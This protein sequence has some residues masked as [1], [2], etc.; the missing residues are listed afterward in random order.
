M[1]KKLKIVLLF[2]FILFF[3]ACDEGNDNPAVDNPLDDGRSESGETN[4]TVTEVPGMGQ[5][6]GALLA[7]NDGTEVAA[8][9]ATIEVESHPEY[10]TTAD[11]EGKVSISNM[12]PGTYTIYAS[13]SLSSAVASTEIKSTATDDRKAQ[14]KDIVVTAAQ[15]TTLSTDIVLTKPGSISGTVELLN[16]PNNVTLGGISVYVPGTS[17]IALTDENGDFVI[18]GVPTGKYDLIQFDKS[19]LTSSQIADITV[20]SDTDT[21]LGVIVMSLSTGPSGEII[22]LDNTSSVTISGTAKDVLQT[23]T[24]TI[25]LKYDSRAVLMKVAHESSFLNVDWVTVASSYT[26]DSSTNPS[27]ITN[28]STDGIKYVYVKFA[29]LNG[30]ESSVYYKEFIIN[31]DKP[32]INS[33]SLLNN[34]SYIANTDQGDG[35]YATQKVP[36]EISA[37]DR[38]TGVKE[39]LICNNSSFSGCST[40]ETYATSKSNWNLNDNTAG[41]KTV[42]IKVKDYVGN[43]SLTSSDSITVTTHTVLPAEHTSSVTLDADQGPY[44]FDND[45]TFSSDLT[46][47]AGTEIY[48]QNSKSI[49][50][51]GTLNLNG[52]SSNS[53][54]M[55]QLASDNCFG[56]FDLSNSIGPHT[57][58]YLNFDHFAGTDNLMDVVFKIN[59][60]TV[61]NSTFDLRKGTGAV[62]VQK[63]SVAPLLITNNIIDL[64]LGNCGNGGIIQI[65]NGIEN[66]ISYNNFIL[67]SGQCP[68]VKYSNSLTDILFEY[69]TI[70]STTADDNCGIKAEGRN[71]II[72][73]NHFDFSASTNQ[74]VDLIYG[75]AA[76]VNLTISYNNMLMYSDAG[77]AGTS[78][79]H[80]KEANSATISVAD[81]NYYGDIAINDSCGSETQSACSN[82]ASY[83]FCHSSLTATPLACVIT[84]YT[85]CSVS[86]ISGCVGSI[87]P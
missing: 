83:E 1:I 66:T 67:K 39:M 62:L 30:L 72:R 28:Y 26:F 49:T 42:Y 21:D 2:S 27:A 75:N 38:G 17:F 15:D 61:S 25:N 32:I 40:W 5:L 64:P 78:S 87:I 73:Y 31:N 33:I 84:E 70:T 59:G 14:F 36:I 46:I 37:S 4:T 11:S 56:G 58:T 35:T 45:L 52:T 77:G 6:S 34:W 60:G 43:E 22:S 54:Y 69:N 53:V 79:V 47:N 10:N 13:T 63:T 16:N 82:N 23:N 48:F 8:A 57:I 41:I 74:S 86:N 80:F 9:N 18:S 76:T 12:L 71:G 44:T 24:V 3:W 50:V 85:K 20:D 68:A 19:G 29:D 51:K 7:D 55:S 81:D 65:T